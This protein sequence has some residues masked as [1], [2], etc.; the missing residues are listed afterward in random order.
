MP[1]K[2]R[3]EAFD[4]ND[5]IFGG[6]VKM[7]SMIEISDLFYN[8][9]NMALLLLDDG[10]TVSIEIPNDDALYHLYQVDEDTFC[11]EKVGY[12]VPKTEMD[13]INTV[14]WLFARAPFI[15]LVGYS[16]I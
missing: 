9:I 7:L 4:I 2:P 6:K 10:E 11:L 3:F 13:A 1:N 15:S 12:D 14:N 5:L 16:N 8:H